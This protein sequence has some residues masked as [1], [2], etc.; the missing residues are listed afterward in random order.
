[1]PKQVKRS[2]STTVWAKHNRR[3]PAADPPA[4]PSVQ[5]ACANCGRIQPDQGREATCIHCGCCPMPSFS[6]KPNSS[7]YPRRRR[8]HLTADQV[9]RA[10]ASQTI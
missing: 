8:G 10:K 6:Y 3:R 9:L 5:V 1:M 2:E 4:E 7:F